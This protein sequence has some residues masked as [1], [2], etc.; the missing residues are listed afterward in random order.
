ML[1]EAIL[2][3]HQSNESCVSVNLMK[4][5]IFRFSYVPENLVFKGFFLYFPPQFLASVNF[6]NFNLDA[7][8]A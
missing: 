6:C 2:G 3:H 7:F 1:D 4:N 8:M 5:I